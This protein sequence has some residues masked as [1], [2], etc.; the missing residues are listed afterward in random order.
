V[1]SPSRLFCI[2][3]QFFL[4]NNGLITYLDHINKYDR[5]YY[6]IIYDVYDVYAVNNIQYPNYCNHKYIVIVLKIIKK[7][8]I[9]IYK[10]CNFFKKHFTKFNILF[11]L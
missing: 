2:K 4:F 5:H 8:T 10:F 1:V 6:N 9:I 3:F 7:N 11:E